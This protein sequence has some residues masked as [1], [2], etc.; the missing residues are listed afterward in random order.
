MS[1]LWDALLATERYMPHGYCLLWQPELVWMHVLADITIALAYF[2]IPTTLLIIL[3]KR[4]RTLPFRWVFIL[5]AAFIFLCGL[6]HLVALVTLWHP[7]YYFE[8]VVKILTAAVSLA[9]AFLMFPLIPRLLD[10]F[11]DVKKP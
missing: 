7:I 4:N 9:T 1:E 6:T 2:A 3:I 5:F 11:E 10:I 8:G